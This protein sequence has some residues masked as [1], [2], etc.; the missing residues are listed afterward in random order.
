LFGIDSDL[1]LE[2]NWG[3]WVRIGKLSKS[4]GF[5]AAVLPAYSTWGVDPPMEHVYN[6]RRSLRVFEIFQEEGIAAIPTIAAYWPAQWNIWATW[7]RENPEVRDIAIDFGTIVRSAANAEWTIFLERLT[8][9][10]EKIGRPVTLH[11]SGVNTID[12]LVEIFAR[13]QSPES[14]RLF[15]TSPIQKATVGTYLGAEREPSLL[16]SL[17]RTELARLGIDTL[18]RR[19]LMA[20]CIVASKRQA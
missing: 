19:R 14:V 2:A 17:S 6:A 12:K 10:L 16:R 5:V 11:I 3:Q 9:L 8:G 1:R 20:L 15:S 7:L 4:L 18:A 13:V